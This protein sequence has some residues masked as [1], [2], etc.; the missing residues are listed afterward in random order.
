MLFKKVSFKSKKVIVN[1][2]FN[3]I[4]SLTFYRSSAAFVTLKISLHCYR[5]CRNKSDKDIDFSVKNFFTA[6]QNCQN[7]LKRP[8]NHN[9]NS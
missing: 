2:F 3:E 6:S 7:S 9:F 1:D 5:S 4:N 8:F